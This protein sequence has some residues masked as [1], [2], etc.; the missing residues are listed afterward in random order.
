MNGQERRLRKIALFGHFD[1]T[2]LGNES[3]LQAMLSNL[4]RL[5]PDTKV[6]CICTNPQVT[7]AV[8]QVETVAVS[9]SLFSSWR[10]RN[11]WGRALR[12]VCIG[13]PSEAYQ[14]VHGLITL[15]GTDMLVVPGTGLLTDAFGFF[16]LS[17]GPYHLLRW[18]LIAK[19]CGCKLLFVSIGA[20]PIYGAL[21]RWA[22]RS[23]LSLA[24]F[25]SYRDNSTKEYLANI[26][27]GE[28]KDQVYPDL[29]FS[30]PEAAIPHQERKKGGRSVVGL[31]LMEYA[32]RYS[33]ANPT[34]KIYSAYLDSLVNLVEWLLARD[35]DIR[36][37]IGDLVDTNAIK[38][39]RNLLRGR[40]SA[41][42]EAHIT[43]EPIG[44]VETLLSQILTT[45][46]VV[47]TRFHNVLLAILCDKPVIAV[48]FHHK[49]ESLMNAIGLPEYCLDINNLSGDQLI[50][51]AC[52]VENDGERIR[53][54]IRKKMREFRAALEEQYKII[55]NAIATS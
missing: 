17:W 4:R 13:L 39:F 54:T 33:V 44:S 46:F 3:S 35:Y 47:A 37:L 28:G 42:D 49:C 15:W 26:G 53:Y 36:L 10:P 50:T 20:G 30:L 5:K 2:N 22:V 12:R 7:K 51:K 38:D 14:W 21:G 9:R 11:P 16:R 18:S 8:H 55:F 34:D 24:D 23:T 19:L 41:R 6:I 52:D 40:I 27:C 45:D 43:E 32:G 31:G 48:S 1:S 25:R 29:A